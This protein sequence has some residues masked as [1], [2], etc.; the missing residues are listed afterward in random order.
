MSHA[1]RFSIGRLPAALLISLGSAAC[2]QSLGDLQPGIDLAAMDLSA[3]PCDDFY[4]YACG[5]YID[6]TPLPSDGS[7]ASRSSAAYYATQDAQRAILEG[8]LP[9]GPEGAALGSFNE[10][11]LHAGNGTQSTKAFTDVITRIDITSTPADFAAAVAAVHKLGLTALFSFGSVRN[12]E[13]PGKRIAYVGESNF[14]MPDRSYYLDPGSPELAAYRDHIEKLSTLVGLADPG[15]ADAVIGIETKIAAAKLPADDR[16]DPSLTFHVKDRAAFEASMPSF[17]WAT[18]RSWVGAPSYEA[19][20]VSV[21]EYF[22]ALESILK[23]TPLSD[24][25]RYLRYRATEAVAYAMGDAVLAEEYAFHYGVFYG[26]SALLPRPEFCLRQ[27]SGALPWA[28]SRAYVERVPTAEIRDAVTRMSNGLSGALRADLALLPWLDG[29]T[30]EAAVTKLDAMRIEVAAPSTWPSLEGLHIDAGSFVNA[31]AA[32]AAFEMDKDVRA[33]GTDDNDDWFMAPVTV[34][35][36]YSPSS[37]AVNLPVA[38]L[39]APYFDV[40]HAPAVQLGAMGSIIGHELTHG[41]DDQGRLFD[42]G[43]KL[44]NWWTKQDEADFAARAQC[45]VDRYSSIEALPGEHIDGALTLGE[46]IADI[47]GVKLAYV[48]AA[49]GDDGGELTDRQAFFVAHAQMYCSVIRPELLRTLL[50]TDPHAPE[51]ARVNEVLAQRPEFAAA[52]SCSA[53]ARMAPITRCEVW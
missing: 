42:G 30:R 37:N 49:P 18:Y 29:A 25:K 4:R 46:N 5:G 45:L 10:A 48:A 38:I 43:G 40:D 22:V 23:S 24:L 7:W 41:F 13:S 16:R 53:G 15:L 32:V 31:Y 33:I 1:S 39:Q 6:S 17:D 14:P 12:L 3:D 9:P 35:A 27:T 8:A 26:F 50:R 19:L 11:C 20:D 2:S 36:A 44:S 51:E 21:P 47:G 52:F 34:N 28:M